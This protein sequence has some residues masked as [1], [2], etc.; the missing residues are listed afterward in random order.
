MNPRLV[1][2]ALGWLSLLLNT[3]MA[4]PAK[5][6]LEP[7]MLPTPAGPTLRK[8]G[9]MEP[10]LPS[11]PLNERRPLQ[12]A[13]AQSR[14]RLNGLPQTEGMGFPQADQGDVE[15]SAPDDSEESTPS[16]HL[17]YYGR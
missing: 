2:A 6:Q 1:P 12:L 16:L 7:L 13:P 5:L 14:P 9:E 4:Q 11:P 8:P 3:A 17:R 15:E 10:L